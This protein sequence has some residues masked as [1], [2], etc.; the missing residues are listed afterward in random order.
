MYDRVYNTSAVD[1]AKAK[2]AVLVGG[3]RGS[4]YNVSVD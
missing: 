4:L 3:D 1:G 2:H